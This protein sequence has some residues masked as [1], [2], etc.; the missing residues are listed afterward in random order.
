MKLI[1]VWALL[2]A[3]LLAL[4]LVAC[5]KKT[6]PEE[7]TDN[8]ATS[9]DT[10]AVTETATEGV[11]EIATETVAAVVTEPVTEIVEELATEVI[12]QPLT[13]RVTESVT[14]VVTEMATEVETE[15]DTES[16]TQAETEAETEFVTE[17]VTEAEEETDVNFITQT[18]QNPVAP[19][20]AD[21]WVIRHGDKYYY[22]YSYTYIAP[23]WSK[24]EIGVKV[25]AFDSLDQIGEA[26]GETVFLSPGNTAYSWNYWAPELHYLN[27]EWYIY[28]AAD[29]GDNVNH[30]MYVLK[31]T[32]QDPTDPFEF[33]GQITDPTNKWAIDGTILPLN[34]ELYFIWSG[35]E[36]D[37]NVAQNIYIAHMSDPCTIDSQRVCLSTPTYAWEKVGDPHVNEGPAVLQHEGKTFVTYSAS[38]SW[39]DDYC[40][41]LLTLT[42]EDPMNPEHWAKA[43]RPVFYKRA[44]VA[45]GPGHNSFTTAAD[46]SV[47]MVYH[48]N[49]EAGTGWSGRSVWL[50]PVTFDAGGNPVFGRPETVVQLPVAVEYALNG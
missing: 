27:G 4:A 9:A 20:G 47:W 39:T 14:D 5:D 8:V 29:D 26:E 13:E 2:I 11:T 32:T 1:R 34:G 12:T 7:Q 44:G 28:V 24:I 41:G 19:T 3:T 6:A 40:L 38:G 50:A 35:W 17:A 30:R 49:R 10:Q 36:G 46:G 15:T 37:V 23:D 45:Y 33:V 43:S 25:S 48:A 18:V 22:C 42:G 16:V 21:P 31:G